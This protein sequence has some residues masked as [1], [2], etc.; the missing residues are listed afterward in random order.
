[1]NN[2]NVIDEREVLGFD[3]KV[4][5]DADNPL[6]LA[7]DV[8]NWIEHNKPSEMIANVDEDEKLKIKMQVI[9]WKMI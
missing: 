8:A 5:G 7:K 6:F 4:Y 1:M 3:F 2:I 9:L